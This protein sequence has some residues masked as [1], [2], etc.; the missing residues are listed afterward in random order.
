M[1]NFE[2][3]H[4]RALLYFVE[5]DVYIINARESFASQLLTVFSYALTYISIV[6][7]VEL[8]CVDIRFVLETD[9]NYNK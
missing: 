9:E 3:A 1:E 6:K 8:R 5:Y 2:C 7:R 4:S